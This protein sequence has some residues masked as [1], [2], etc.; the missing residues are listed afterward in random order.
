MHVL[1]LASFRIE[2]ADA[3]TDF[4]STVRSLFV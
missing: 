2:W 1:A 4:R 3:A